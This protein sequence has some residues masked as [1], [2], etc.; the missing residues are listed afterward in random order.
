MYKIENSYIYSASDLMLQMRSPFASWMARLSLD[1]PERLVNISKDQD[2]MMELLAKK[3][4]QHETLYL[5][6]LQEEFGL[7]NIIQ[8]E[9][10]DKKVAAKKTLEAMKG[11]YKVIAQAYLQRD[12]F[13]G[14]SDFLVRVEGSSDLGDYYY[15]AWDTK[16]ARSTRPYFAIQ[17]ACYSWMLESIQG[18][19]PDE[20]VVVLG[21]GIKDRFRIAAF[22]SYFQSIKQQFLD[23]QDNFTGDESTR[24]DPALES[25]FGAW[26]AYA[27]SLLTEADSLSL[28]AGITKKQIKHLYD[29]NITTLT[30]L[31]ELN[32]TDLIKGI[33]T[34][35]F[36]K[37]QAQAEIQ[38][39]SMG[40]DKPFFKV[41]QLDNGK[42]LSSLPPASL[43]D[44][45]CQLSR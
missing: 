13:A 12:N 6:K 21:N 24:P 43:L 40:Q 17:L 37:I 19:M 35:T 34:E 32:S 5:A 18:Y 36:E 8:I 39:R 41:I 9:E 45:F 3:G 44:V 30:Q 25:D 2:V 33:P 14:S 38:H 22:Y 16:L 27:K 31:A 20:A 28:V 42:G 26:A 10:R 7:E 29:S 4:D 23:L 15:E 11:G 1:Y